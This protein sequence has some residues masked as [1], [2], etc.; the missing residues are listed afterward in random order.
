LNTEC[1][2]NRVS[3]RSTLTPGTISLTASRDGLQP[4]TVQVASSPTKPDLT[5][6]A[7]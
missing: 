1:G 2:I 3:I 5:A 7:R 6:E 4:A